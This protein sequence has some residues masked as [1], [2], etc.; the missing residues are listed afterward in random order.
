MEELRFNSSGTHAVFLANINTFFAALFALSIFQNGWRD[1]KL[2][3]RSVLQQCLDWFRQMY[4]GGRT[5]NRFHIAARNTARKDLSGR[6]QMIL[7]YVAMFA[8]ESDIESLLNTGVVSKR[9]KTRARRSAQ[10]VSAN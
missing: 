2:G 8:D 10:T 5:G 7:H 9:T 3:S 4:E 6:I 1:D